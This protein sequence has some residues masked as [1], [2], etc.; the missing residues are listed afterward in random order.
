[1]PLYDYRCMSCGDFRELRPMRE[2]GA[3]RPCPVCGATSD[4]VI[5]APFLSGRDSDGEMAR[6]RGRSPG[7][8]NA[9]GHGH[10][11]SHWHGG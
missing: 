8:S 1:M 10:G 5:S 2:S 7:A 3:T 9:C 11:C 6:G 4:R